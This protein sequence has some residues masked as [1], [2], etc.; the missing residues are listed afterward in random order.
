[1]QVNH[2]VEAGFQ[3]RASIHGNNL[4]VVLAFQIAQPAAEVI[5]DTGT[6]RGQVLFETGGQYRIRADGSLLNGYLHAPA[7]PL[8]LELQQ[9]RRAGIGVGKI[10]VVPAVAVVDKELNDFGDLF[11]QVFGFHQQRQVVCRQARLRQESNGPETRN[12]RRH[13]KRGKC[14]QSAQR[15]ANRNDEQ[16]LS[17]A[18]LRFHPGNPLKTEEDVFAARTV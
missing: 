6:D 10:D 12:R 8:P 5:A 1:M 7:G 4:Y 18:P 13:T 14:H 11:V 3:L 9:R 15:L 16:L 2:G 17:L